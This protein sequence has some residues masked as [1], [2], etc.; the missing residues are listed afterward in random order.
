MLHATQKPVEL[1]RRA[2]L[3]HTEPGDC[4]YDPFCGSGTSLIACES[5]GR[6]YCGLELSPTWCDV[7][8]R[9]WQRKTGEAATLEATGQT[10]DEVTAAR[11]ATGA[12]AVLESPGV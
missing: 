4:V 5:E 8:V 3:N 7:T 11:S 2:I 10:F 9:R 6:R 1:V 12:D